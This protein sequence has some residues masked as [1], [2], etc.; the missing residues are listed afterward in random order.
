[1]V[2]LSRFRK[3]KKR[4]N[5]CDQGSCLTSFAVS[6][7][8]VLFFFFVITKMF[9]WVWYELHSGTSCAWHSVAGVLYDNNITLWMSQIAKP[10]AF[11]LFF[12]TI[13]PN[14]IC[15]G[16]KNSSKSLFSR[17]AG[18]FDSFHGDASSI[19]AGFWWFEPFYA[20]VAANLLSFRDFLLMSFWFALL[21]YICWLCH[22][23]PSRYLLS[24]WFCIRED[25]GFL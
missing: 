21:P 12:I 16:S 22:P 20:E 17:F 6:L 15:C 4:E 25:S 18:F 10:H 8:R 5:L 23:S 9:D 7:G 24:A 1:M 3:R 13:S 14:I 19:R 11:Y 2:N